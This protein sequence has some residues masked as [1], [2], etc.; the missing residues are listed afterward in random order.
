MVKIDNDTS[1]Y[2]ENTAVTRSGFA[3]RRE[4]DVVLPRP[5][6]QIDQ[7]PLCSR[8]DDRICEGFAHERLDEPWKLSNIVAVELSLRLVK[9]NPVGKHLFKMH[10]SLYC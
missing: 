8:L 7:L 6:H 9:S 5:V 10:F 3:P 4:R 2:R 1:L